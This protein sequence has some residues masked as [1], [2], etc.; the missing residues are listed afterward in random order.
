L[1][2]KKKNGNWKFEKKET[3]NAAIRFKEGNMKYTYFTVNRLRKIEF[4]INTK[5]FFFTEAV[6]SA[7]DLVNNA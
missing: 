3:K 1:L 5:C 6:S 4:S 2:K 7:F